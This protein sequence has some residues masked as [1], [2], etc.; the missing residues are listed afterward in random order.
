MLDEVSSQILYVLSGFLFG[1]FS[2]RYGTISTNKMKSAW[3]EKGFWSS[4]LLTAMP[5]FIFLIIAVFLFPIWMSTR[6][7]LG[8]F[9][10]L[11]TF[12]Y[13]TARNRRKK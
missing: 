8:A 10:Y 9:V 13:Y 12:I 5:S 3:A 4:F 1:V 11:A 6:T 2:C 7:E